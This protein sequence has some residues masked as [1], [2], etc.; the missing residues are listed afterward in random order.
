MKIKKPFFWNK[1]K[2]FFSFILFPF[3]I[4]FQ[5]LG[6]L[7]YLITSKR[8]F[9]IPVIC[10]GNI[11]VGGTGKTP[12][13]LKIAEMLKHIKKKPSIVK[14]FYKQHSDEIALIRSKIDCLEVDTN[15]VNALRKIESKDYNVAILDDGFQDNSIVKD[16]NILC[17][18]ENQLIGNGMV[19]PSGPLRQPLNSIKKSHIIII[20]GSTNIN[21]ENLIYKFSKDIVI[22]YSKYIPTNIDKFKDKELLAFAGIG[23]PENFFHLLDENN[24]SIKKKISFPDHYN[25]HKNELE[26]ILKI[27][28]E[29]NL[30]VITT[31]KDYF[32]INEMGFSNINYLKIQLKIKHEEDLLKEIKKYI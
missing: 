26:D 23:N 15:R 12:L 8:K 28:K 27:A 18:N 1:K 2:N 11:Y 7:N 21:F 4:I 31:E 14:K 24:L 6:V 16:L 19:M 3:S 20:N 9:S 30:E 25:Y 32:R 29:N 5:I 22:F 10:V 13:C 17:F